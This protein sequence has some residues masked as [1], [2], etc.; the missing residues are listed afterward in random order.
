MARFR[1]RTSE[2]QGG[3][4]RVAL[5][6][7]LAVCADGRREIGDGRDIEGRV[8]LEMAALREVER[9]QFPTRA[10]EFGVRLSAGAG[11]ARGRREC[12]RRRD[13]GVRRR[14]RLAQIEATAERLLDIPGGS[15]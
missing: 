3:A 2:V 12:G 11:I 4:R 15:P 14:D 8:L 10:Q 7:R 1:A 6:G 9:R 13:E 5:I